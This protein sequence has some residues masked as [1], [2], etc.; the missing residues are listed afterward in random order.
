M[1]SNIH[2]LLRNKMSTSFQLW[3]VDVLMSTWFWVPFKMYHPHISEM[4]FDHKCDSDEDL[5]LWYSE[6]ISEPSL[7]YWS[8]QVESALLLWLE[9]VFTQVCE[10][11]LE[12]R[13]CGFWQLY[14]GLCPH[15]V[16]H[17]PCRVYQTLNL[18]SREVQTAG[19][20]HMSS[21]QRR[22]CLG[23]TTKQILFNSDLNTQWRRSGH[24]RKK[25]TQFY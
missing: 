19:A 18:L 22:R 9:S 2:V 15:I 25:A 3:R 21:T 20:E 1:T 23:L 14:T 8:K 24:D 12:D 6:N 17:V 11:L 5:L 10:P 13:L 7:Y 16:C 4:S